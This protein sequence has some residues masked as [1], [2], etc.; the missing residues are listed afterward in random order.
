MIKNARIIS[1]GVDI[2]NGVL[3]AVD[4][5]IV[6]VGKTAPEN[7]DGEIIDAA[8]NY[9][10]PGF[11]DSHCHGGVNY[12]FC[13][14]DAKGAAKI[15]IHKLSEGVTTLLPTTLTVS[16]EN[17][18]DA[19]KSIAEYDQTS[20]AKIPGVHL[21]GPFISAKCLGAQN[22][23]FVRAISIDEVD[24]LD[25]VFPVK[26]VTF[27]VEEQGG[28]KFIADLKQRKM[29]PSCT[30]SQAS[31]TAFTAAHQAG[32]RNLSH[33]CNQMTPLHHRDIGLVG[34]GLLHDDV[35]AELICDTLH[36]SVPMI[37][38][39]FKVKGADKVMLISDAMR[40]AGMPEG[41][42][43]LGGLP[44]IV[45][46][47]AARL[48]EGGALA[49]STLLINTALKNVYE[50]TGLPLSEVV[51]SATSTPAASLG[52]DDIG[53][54]EAGM[55]ADMVILDKNFKVLQTFVNGECRYKA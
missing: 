28:E 32:L 9:L 7:F 47:G 30:H 23:A 24:R 49:G 22:P 44:V 43:T 52:M 48:K 51:K 16:E 40:A 38:L 15:A 29:V 19:L 27:A 53:K 42:Y 10:M 6:S 39:T 2:D 1:A 36:I 55:L 5:K 11:I 33:F 12:D 25:A 41:E 35:F 50:I 8:G 20:G 34:A 31:Y 13:D 17:L 3:T 54:L 21:E 14:A 37:K 4:G 26:K 45:K 18:V 46:D